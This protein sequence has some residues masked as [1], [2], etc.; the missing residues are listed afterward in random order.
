MVIH[1][2]R[3]FDY[4]EHGDYIYKKLGYFDHFEN[5]GYEL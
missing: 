2:T 1:Q 5:Y 4:V 3:H